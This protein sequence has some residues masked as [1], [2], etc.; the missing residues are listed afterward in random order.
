[1]NIFSYWDNVQLPLLN[2]YCISTWEK[3]NPDCNVIILNDDNL[4]SYVKSVPDNF[5][6]L[7]PQHKSDYIRTYLLYHYGGVWID[8]TIIIN[9]HLSNLFDFTNK[10]TIQ[11]IKSR[12][13]HISIK[14]KYIPLYDNYYFENSFICCLEPN[15]KLMGAI[16]DNFIWC[17]DNLSIDD[18]LLVNSKKESIYFKRIY[19][20]M[21]KNRNH[22][23]L[24]NWAYYLTHMNIIAILLKNSDIYDTCYINTKKIMNFLF[25]SKGKFFFDSNVGHLK[26]ERQNRKLVTELIENGNIKEHTELECWID[27]DFF[28]P[29]HI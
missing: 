22:F 2:K 3:H 20:N 21:I 6:K 15:N 25:Y 7:I 24:G 18:N 28:T 10:H 11:F 12:S 4:H 19:T 17:I 14:K 29:L 13:A 26:I 8:C 5:D 23:R 1:M 16:L 9:T 27:L